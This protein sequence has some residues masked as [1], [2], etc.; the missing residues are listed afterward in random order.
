MPALKP[1][2]SV[3]SSSPAHPTPK[4][5]AVRTNLFPVPAGYQGPELQGSL[6]KEGL[7]FWSYVD[8]ILKIFTFS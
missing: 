6:V 5:H 2:T 1:V 4:A 3:P 8:D 7:A